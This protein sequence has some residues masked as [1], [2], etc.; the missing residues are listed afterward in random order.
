MV[1][2]VTAQRRRG[3]VEALPRVGKFPNPGCCTPDIEWANPYYPALPSRGFIGTV[4]AFTPDLSVELKN[5]SREAAAITPADRDNPTRDSSSHLQKAFNWFSCN[6]QWCRE[7]HEYRSSGDWQ[8]CHQVFSKISIYVQKRP[9][10]SYIFVNATLHLYYHSRQISL[11]IS[12]RHT[13]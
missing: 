2:M 10:I 5:V 1:R 4:I 11:S 3:N 7:L 13:H 6:C 8:T 12:S 9:E